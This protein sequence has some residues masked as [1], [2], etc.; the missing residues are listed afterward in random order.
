MPANGDNGDVQNLGGFIGSEA[1]EETQFDQFPFQGIGLRQSLQSIIDG[2]NSRR[3]FH[4]D[5]GCRVRHLQGSSAA[6][7]RMAHAG[8]VDQDL[9]H[10]LGGDGHKVRASPKVRNLLLHEAGIGLVNHSSRLQRMAVVFLAHV[11]S[12]EPSQFRIE[13]GHERVERVLIALRKLLQQNGDGGVR[14]QWSELSHS[15]RMTR[16]FDT[17]FAI[18]P[19]V[20]PKACESRAN[21]ALSIDDSTPKPSRK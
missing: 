10:D 7:A 13:E 19:Y 6:L 12:S 20:V 2:E 15:C 4:G 14:L 16:T 11:A 3:L 21:P 9:A 1:A 5:V 8:V 18:L 17:V